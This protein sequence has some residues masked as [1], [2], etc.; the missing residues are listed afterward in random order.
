MSETR[1]DIAIVGLGCRF[2]GGIDSPE[3]FWR[4]LRR[5]G[6]AVVPVSPAR[7]PQ[8]EDDD[9]PSCRGARWAALLDDV[10]GFDAAFF[11]ISAH[12]ARSLDPQQRLLLEVS[13][14]ALE[15]AGRDPSQL[16]G[17]RTGIY[18][19]ATSA[20]HRD[21]LLAR[22][23]LRGDA[24]ATS[25]S[26]LAFAAG[27][28][29]FFLGTRG[30]ALTVDTACS[31]SL[32][33]VH[34]ACQAL[35]TG[36]VELALAGGVN[37]LLSPWTTEMLARTQALSPDG[38]CKAF[39]A[40]ANGFVR[41]EGC[42][43]VV[44]QR[45]DAALAAGQR[46]WAVIRGS[47]VNQDGRSS[48]LMAPNGR[49][50][51]ELLRETW[52]NAGVAPESIGYLEA[53]GTGTSLG[54]PIEMDAIRGALGASSAVDSPCYVG[55]VK[56]NFGH[57]EAAA[58]MAGLMKC[59]LALQHERVPRQLHLRHLNP[60]IG[61]EGTRLEVAGQEVAWP[62][63][64]RARFA[65][66][67]AFGLSGTN[68]H[69]VLEEAPAVH[70]PAHT[71]RW[72]VLPLSARD[73]EALEALVNAYREFL[74]T[75]D[76]DFASVART[77]AVGRAHFT[78]RR[79]IVARD[80][81]EALRALDAPLASDA[82]DAE[83]Q[84]M[85][86][87][88]RDYAGGADIDWKRVYGAGGATVS[89]PTYRFQRRRFPR[90]G[91]SSAFT[92]SLDGHPQLREH[93]Y[94]GTPVA[95]AA[96]YLAAML[97][98]IAADEELAGVAFRAPLLLTG[99]ASL[100]VTQDGGAF[101]A[102]SGDGRVHAEGTVRRGASRDAG[103][104]FVAPGGDGEPAG[105]ALHAFLASLGIELGES[106]RCAQNVWRLRGEAFAQLRPPASPSGFEVGELDSVLQTIGLVIPREALPPNR[107][108]V[109]VSAE[110]VYAAELHS[111]IAWGHARLRAGAN[112]LADLRAYDAG[113]RL[114]LEI[115]GLRIA[116]IAPDVFGATRPA[117]Q[118][119]AQETELVQ[120]L[121][122][123]RAEERL[124]LL[125]AEVRAAAEEVLQDG[126]RA[127]R[128]DQPLTEAGL[129]SLAAVEMAE[130]LERSAGRRLSDTLLFDYP[131]IGR[132]TQHLATVL[133]PDPPPAAPAV[134]AAPANDDGIA[135][136]GI[137]CRFPGGAHD[138]DTLWQLLENGADAVAEIPPG[139]WDVD[140][141]YDPAPGA[142]GKMYSRRM[143]S[144][145]EVDRFDAGFFGIAPREAKW[146]DPQQRL[147]LE[148]S[149]EAL[150]HAGLAPDALS[151]SCTGVFLGIST[152]DY[153]RRHLLSGDASRI[154]AMAATGTAFNS[155][156]G[157][158]SYVFGFQGPNIA[159]DT[160]CSSSLV[161]V[162]LA[163]R[164]L[165]DGESD[166][167]LAGGVNLILSPEY[168]VYFSKV[169]A[170]SPTG[171]CRAFDAAADGYVRGEGC[172]MVVLKR[173]ADARAAGDRVL[174]VIRGSA[175]NQDGRSQG[176]TAP[177]GPA[178]EAVIRRA[179]QK[180][181]VAPREVGYVE[182]HGTGTPLGDPIEIQ[183]LANVFAEKR[184]HAD[185]LVVGSL[186][187]N[188]G[189][190][191][192]AS[193]IAGLIKAVLCVQ[194]GQI[195]QSLHITTPNPR[196]DWDRIAVR[197]ATR[198]AA[199]PQGG[200]RIA[201]V[202][203]FGF[204]GTNAHV[205]VAA[206]DEVPPVAHAAAAR[207]LPLSAKSEAALDALAR[208][209][210][211]WLRLTNAA[212][213][214]IAFTASRR[215][216]H[217]PHRL[218]VI[219][220]S[221]A[222]WADAL[223]AWGRAAGGTRVI[224]RSTEPAEDARRIAESYV[225]GR[226]VDWAGVA[227]EGRCI[228]LPSYAWQKERHWMEPP[229]LDVRA[230]DDSL[231]GGRLRTGGNEVEFESRLSAQHPPLLGG[232]RIGPRT[233]MAGAGLLSM[234]AAAARIVSGRAAQRVDELR[235]HQPLVL[236]ETPRALRT[237]LVPTDDGWSFRIASRVEEQQEWQLH[238]SG[239]IAPPRQEL[240]VI[241]IAS[242]RARCGDERESAAFYAELRAL[243]YALSPAF[244]RLTHI[245]RRA[246]ESLCTIERVREDWG[247]GLRAA[248]PGLLD[249]CFQAVAAALP[250]SGPSERLARGSI[251]VP[252]AV[253]AAELR[254]GAGERIHCHAVIA[255]ESGHGFSGT[256]EI[257]G[258]DGQLLAAMRVEFQSVPQTMFLG[259]EAPR[260]E[261]VNGLREVLE[262]A[263]PPLRISILADFI[264]CALAESADLPPE[265][266][267]V[268]GSFDDVG[269]TS[270][271]AFEVA[272]RLSDEL[273]IDVSGAALW[274]HASTSRLAAHLIEQLG[275][276]SPAAPTPR[277]R[278]DD[279]QSM[280][281]RIGSLSPAEVDHWISQQIGGVLDAE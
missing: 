5:G 274:S 211:R 42:G 30:P 263:E 214:D 35:R 223:E 37:V 94:F 31:S 69:V 46:I 196:I 267:A 167:A 201:G 151:G 131:T 248:H 81:T 143:A 107:V 173:L 202:S 126:A 73:P 238:A 49:A 34:L 236:E 271:V 26:I 139:R 120:R 33:A 229:P 17:S 102:E 80:G 83:R 152:A 9:D 265:M 146:I 141:W 138:P 82:N 240:G 215:R 203:A 150:E 99:G 79:A 40:S 124:E 21:Q 20:D 110:R 206:G 142:A 253:D 121:R 39:D 275:L 262:A 123:A 242:L 208:K 222:A 176:M 186:K 189:H 36:E 165:A 273:R 232:H 259:A 137:G 164:S 70:E 95:P 272:Q 61:L 56:T 2:P 193:G 134:F 62:R 270:L 118:A 15:Q 127:L 207:L 27:R 48:G 13:W 195:P 78:H 44:L 125:R 268:D 50:Q 192:A 57:L 225:A 241:D 100:R 269:M 29:A 55:S 74:A 111:A 103:A 117:A 59:V 278:R 76:G 108:C 280:L 172:G 64:E 38:R 205:V 32:T 252:V 281:D 92:I 93:C 279:L 226:A 66:V 67:S 261:I 246:G 97:E 217:H 175:V 277:P 24:Y 258:D 155:T 4:F 160:A 53:H 88:A 157:R 191:E 177:N 86:A 71:R 213:A 6:D 68:A 256:L 140:A 250:G 276:A 109:P 89:L 105:D 106:F 148:V 184:E 122:G 47:G 12:E 135:I 251:F 254:L 128:D 183:A 14:E 220:D 16:T 235:F 3:S 43:V 115:D 158:I 249:S 233:I 114:L 11:G 145:E 266:V 25:G 168:S 221:R 130:A 84:A 52:R 212:T 116:W 85:E 60:R 188:L 257:A 129:D 216:T 18:I 63:G 132:L 58:G 156:A 162:H 65:A 87:L 54:D 96:F 200:P 72:C 91:A 234:A 10:E 171:R 98:R 218:A 8:G 154:E 104:R 45:L 244:A 19:G 194:H 77:A 101:R 112:D 178:Q 166:L 181:R 227:P 190:L 159:L 224:D 197:P 136:I 161:A 7:W 163:C 1:V 51:E 119:N 149:W 90:I 182:A 144:V 170:L 245:R 174:A 133:L 187:S 237:T 255:D 247:D 22:E 228:A 239:R 204:S 179:L 147:L 198:A 219:G 199:W 210:S 169:G 23:D 264:R 185:P 28:L 41:G 153:A 243:G 113:G 260:L 180:A 231:L 230:A 209:W 75:H